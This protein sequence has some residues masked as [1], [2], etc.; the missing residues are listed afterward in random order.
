MT[1][2]SPS[3]LRSRVL[4]ISPSATARLAASSATMP[5]ARLVIQKACSAMTL[6]LA[7]GHRG[8]GVVGRRRGRRRGGGGGGRGGRG[9][10]GAPWGCPP[11]PR[12]PGGRRPHHPP[13][14]HQRGGGG[15]RR[16]RRGQ[17]GP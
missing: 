7:R 1:R 2:R 9:R 10:G 3:R 4:I 8:R 6:G 11:P 12:P 17:P 13:R 5:A 15:R 16:R 14:A